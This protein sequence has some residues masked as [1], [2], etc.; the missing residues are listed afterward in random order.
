MGLDNVALLASIGVNINSH[1]PE[2]TSNVKSLI[3]GN[4]L[5]GVRPILL[6]KN[7]EI[8]WEF[9]PNVGPPTPLLE[10]PRSKQKLGDFVKNLS[11]FRVILV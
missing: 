10:T 3:L 8:I 1:R 6:K 7:Y 4:T 9:F 2:V 5:N 11:F